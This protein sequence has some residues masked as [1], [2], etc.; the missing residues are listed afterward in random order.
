MVYAPLHRLKGAARGAKGQGRGINRFEHSRSEVDE[1][2]PRMCAQLSMRR[3]TRIIV[4][5]VPRYSR[6][7]TTDPPPNGAAYADEGDANLWLSFYVCLT[8][9]QRH[10]AGAFAVS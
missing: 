7:M 4:I 5:R 6:L 9:K 8:R 3:N 10:A 2:L 1:A